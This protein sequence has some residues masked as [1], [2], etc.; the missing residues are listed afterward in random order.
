MLGLVVERNRQYPHSSILGYPQVSFGNRRFDHGFSSEGAVRP[1]FPGRPCTELR[2]SIVGCIPYSCTVI[3]IHL[4]LCAALHQFDEE[5]CFGN[6]LHEPW[7]GLPARV[8]VHSAVGHTSE[9]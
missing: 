8:W 2:R 6:F 7:L 3:Q 9:K 4:V 5:L 1:L